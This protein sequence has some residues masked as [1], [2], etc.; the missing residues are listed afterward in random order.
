VLQ[1][2]KNNISW[3][4][5]TRKFASDSPKKIIERKF[6][7]T[8]DLN[9]LVVG[10]LRA[11]GIKAY[12][13]LISTRDHGKIMIDYPFA[14]YFNNVI[15]LAE[16]DD[17]LVL[18]DATEIHLKNNTIPPNCINDNGLIIQDKKTEWLLLQVNFP[19]QTKTNIVFD[20][21][22]AGWNANI[23]NSY[24]EYD[25]L[26]FKM[27]Y[28]NKREQL[29]NDLNEN[30][31]PVSD[32][33]V[34]VH[35]IEEVDLP[36]ELLIRFSLTPQKLNEKLFV[37]PFLNEVISENPF[38][39]KERKYPVDFIYPMR[40]S[41]QSSIPVPQGYE[42]SNQP[43]NLS[44]SNDIFKLFYQINQYDGVVI[45]TFD[46]ELKKAVYQ[47]QEY[48]KIKFYFDQIVKKGNEQLVLSFTNRHTE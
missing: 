39:Q 1:Y 19:S 45:V 38:K 32:T 41:Y 10:F 22:S 16:F 21:D 14:H 27:K 43:D 2:V 34:K 4:S 47:P 9:L 3:D 36:T 6:G 12:P 44:I 13:V 15:V 40:R 26:A 29:K 25:A 17:Q 42:V 33:S 23:K 46:Y 11:L 24:T 5:K 28:L 20:S 18:T 48:T 37:K 35:H 8:A 30:G 31:Y 7:N